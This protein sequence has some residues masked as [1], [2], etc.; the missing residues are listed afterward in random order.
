MTTSEDG[1]KNKKIDS[2]ISS[3][4]DVIVPIIDEIRDHLVS[5]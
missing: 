2:S 3:S 4:S 1:D 5:F